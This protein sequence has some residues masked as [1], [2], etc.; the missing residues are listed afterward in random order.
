MNIVC[1]KKGKTVIFMRG[2]IDMKIIDNRY[3]IEELMSESLSGSLYL[4]TDL[5]NNDK[6]HFLK[7]YNYS[8]N[9]YMNIINYF[10]DEFIHISNIKHKNLL[11][12]E[13]F[14]IVKSID[15]SLIHI[16]EPTRH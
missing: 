16:S 7:F 3:K 5:W 12:S 8:Y 15:L 1:I 6:R 13:N 11:A 4:V 14:K 9:K 10:M 2:R